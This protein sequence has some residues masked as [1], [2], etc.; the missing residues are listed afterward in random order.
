MNTFNFYHYKTLS[1]FQTDLSNGTF[2]E[3]DLAFIKESKQLYTHGQYY[4]CTGLDEQQIKDLEQ[5]NVIDEVLSLT[6]DKMIKSCGLNPDLTFSSD[7]EIISSATTIA[8][9]IEKIAQFNASGGIPDAP[10]DGKTYG[11]QDNKWVGIESSGSSESPF[12]YISLVDYI[13]EPGE[14]TVKK[15]LELKSILD[16]CSVTYNESSDEVT[17]VP[18]K[19]LLT[20]YSICIG[21]HTECIVNED[22]TAYRVTGAQVLDGTI[23]AIAI[24]ITVSGNTANY[25]FIAKSGTL[26]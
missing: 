11:R 14:G 10:A 24:N 15:W 4:D 23:C 6:V 18:T 5:I 21:I 3:N 13:G 19:F 9:A 16:Q 7:N 8:E 20:G 17:A 25:N 26:Q 22:K 2:T 1:A 12:I